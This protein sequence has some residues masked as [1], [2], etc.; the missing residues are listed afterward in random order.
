MK[1]EPPAVL[2]IVFNRPEVARGLLECMRACRPAQLFIAADGPRPQHETDA[3]R[4]EETRRVFDGV[5]WPCEVKTL[6]QDANLGLK[7]GVIAAIDWFFE[8]V[9]RGI[10]LEDDCHP[11]PEF[12]DFAGEILERYADEP[13]VMHVSGCNMRP[14]QTFSP[15]SYFFAEVGHIWGWATWRRA[16]ALYDV[17]MRAWPAIRHTCSLTSPPLRR[18][19]G[20]K[21]A[22]AYAGRKASWSRIWYYTVMRHRGLAVIPAVNF[23]R[24]VGFGEDATHTNSDRSHPLRVEPQGELTFPLT[25]PTDRAPN[26]AYERHLL[27]FHRGR[28]VQ[29]LREWWFLFLDHLQP[30]RSHDS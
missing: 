3:Q 1:N 16:W 7:A 5:D 6:H 30:Q 24:N 19:L 11:V 12:L 9:D 23:V 4:C 13:E 8:H 18:A 10:I 14:D 17:D 26:K 2:L 22:S 28:H 20:R 15:E 27:H 29:R 21:F 25:H